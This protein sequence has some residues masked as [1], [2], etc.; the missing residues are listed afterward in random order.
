LY[1]DSAESLDEIFH[2]SD[3]INNAEVWNPDVHKLSVDAHDVTNTNLRLYYKNYNTPING[4]YVSSWYRLEQLVDDTWVSITPKH[5]LPEDS[6]IN[7]FNNKIYENRNGIATFNWNNTYGP[8]PAGQYRIITSVCN[9]F[10]YN[11]Q[12]HVEQLY[13]T[14][15][16]VK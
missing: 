15:F 10:T 5:E 6:K 4:L 3:I 16:T 14:E 11:T 9:L 12:N 2:F 8:L 1:A 13:Y 7:I